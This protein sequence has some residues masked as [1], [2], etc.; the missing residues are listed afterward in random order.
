MIM[1]FEDEPAYWVRSVAR[2]N[3]ETRAAIEALE[4][5]IGPVKEEADLGATMRLALALM[6]LRDTAPNLAPGSCDFSDLL[7]AKTPSTPADR[8]TP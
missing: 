7:D 5:L 1:K 2:R 4:R 3:Q 6:A 8:P